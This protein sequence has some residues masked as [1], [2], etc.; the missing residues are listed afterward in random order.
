MVCAK[1]LLQEGRGGRE[2]LK[3][4]DRELSSAILNAV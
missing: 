2:P 4:N 1:S 3:Q